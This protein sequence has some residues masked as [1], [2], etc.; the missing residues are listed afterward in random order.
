MRG[1]P[2]PE[3]QQSVG[4]GS[5]PACAGE[6][7]CRASRARMI[8][9][10]SPLV[11]GNRQVVIQPLRDGRSIPACAGE[12]QPGIVAMVQQWVYPRLC[13]G[14]WVMIALLTAA[15]GL[16]PLVR[17]NRQPPCANSAASRSIPAC[18]G[19]PPPQ[20]PGRHV[21]QVYPR[22]CGGTFRHRL[23]HIRRRGLSPLVRGN[24]CAPVPPA[25]HKRSIPACAGEPRIMPR[26]DVQRRVY[27]RLCGGT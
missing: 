20:Q 25:P 7:R 5:I 27:P 24:H 11:R 17:G 15:D 19:E 14:T 1:N 26:K 21:R 3:Y 23:A 2:P 9:G 8:S 22:L 12:P 6:P 16:S 13:G 4:R 18:A 10:L